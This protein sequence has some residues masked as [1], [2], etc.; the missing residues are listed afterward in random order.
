VVL[1]VEL[2]WISP[3]RTPNSAGAALSGLPN[4]VVEASL[5]RSGE[6]LLR[7]SAENPATEKN[8][9]LKRTRTDAMFLK[10]QCE[11]EL[12]IKNNFDLEI[13]YIQQNQH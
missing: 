9:E 1:P 10:N 11:N 6:E 3:L 4:S 5:W 8:P 7:S 2:R 13:K 12:N